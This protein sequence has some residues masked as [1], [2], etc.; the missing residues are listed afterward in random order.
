[1]KRGIITYQDKITISM[2][3]LKERLPTFR[4]KSL[5]IAFGKGYGWRCA[6]KLIGRFETVWVIGK[7]DFAYDFIA[8]VRNEVFR[9]PLMQYHMKLG[10]SHM[11]M[12]VV[13]RVAP[14]GAGG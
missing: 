11:L 5:A 7:Q 9:F 1:M 10:V 6:I 2:D 13:R 4:T 3:I 14:T 8:D 12:L